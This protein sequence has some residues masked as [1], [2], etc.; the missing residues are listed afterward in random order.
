MIEF[1]A[2]KFHEHT[3]ISP[4]VAHSLKTP[5]W[6]SITMGQNLNHIGVVERGHIN[7]MQT[8]LEETWVFKPKIRP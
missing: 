4:A 1:L 6:G 8:I 7:H 2:P 3:E 5:L